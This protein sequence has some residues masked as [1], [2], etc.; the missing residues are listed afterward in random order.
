MPNKIAW[1]ILHGKDL[2]MQLKIPNKTVVQFSPQVILLQKQLDLVMERFNNR[3]QDLRTEKEKTHDKALTTDENRSA[4][5]NAKRKREKK[6][7]GGTSL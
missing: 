3:I 5:L 1:E 2:V 4:I 6:K 7:G